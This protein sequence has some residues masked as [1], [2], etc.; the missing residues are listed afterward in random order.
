MRRA[1]SAVDIVTSVLIAMML[2]PF[3][4]ARATLGPVMH[5]AGVLATCVIVQVLYFGVCA[6]V[7]RKTLGMHLAGIRLGNADG[8]APARREALA[9]A[10]VSA[11]TA[12]WHVAAPLSANVARTAERLSHTTV[13]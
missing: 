1:Q 11:V 7:W 4:I 3:P 13:Y 2:W 5:I 10:L 9:W 6:V 8:G 12:P